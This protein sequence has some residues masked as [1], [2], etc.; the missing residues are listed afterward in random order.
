MSVGCEASR[1][2]CQPEPVL[3][4]SP[5]RAMQ[6]TQA[7]VETEVWSPE[8]FPGVHV[9]V[10]RRIRD[11]VEEYFVEAWCPDRTCNR[12]KQYGIIKMVP[13]G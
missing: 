5:L 3:V 12:S 9:R 11:G 8:S 6:L 13:W 2:D 10:S 7:G 1:P 4:E